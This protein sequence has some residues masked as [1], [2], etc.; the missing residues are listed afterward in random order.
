MNHP[1][2]VESA[3]RGPLVSVVPSGLVIVIMKPVKKFD[4]MR[5]TGFT[6]STRKVT[7]TCWLTPMVL[8]AGEMKV[9]VSMLVVMSALAK[10]RLI[11]V[12]IASMRIK[13][14]VV[15]TGFFNCFIFLS[16]LPFFSL[17]LLFG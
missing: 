12:E 5:A 17:I 16:P 6:L 3:E 7:M 2:L 4:L 11:T 10:F 14:V 8:G 1:V 15:I 9:K 13:I